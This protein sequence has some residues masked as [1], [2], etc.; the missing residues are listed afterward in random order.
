MLDFLHL[1]AGI[2]S[3]Q[4]PPHNRPSTWEGLRLTTLNLSI[5]DCKSRLDLQLKQIGFISDNEGICYQKMSKFYNL[6]RWFIF[7]I[8]KTYFRTRLS[9][10][11]KKLCSWY[12][13]LTSKS[14]RIFSASPLFL[15]S[16]KYF[17]FKFPSSPFP[18]TA[19]QFLHNTYIGI[20]FLF[21]DACCFS[22]WFL[23]FRALTIGH[24]STTHRTIS[25]EFQIVFQAFADLRIHLHLLIFLRL[26][27]LISLGTLYTCTSAAR[28]TRRFMGLNQDSRSV[29]FSL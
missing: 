7:Y 28:E 8:T 13:N 25:S 22:S 9:F 24:L 12:H 16:S 2:D 4:A 11:F 20:G 21:S 29:L 19:V 26:Y 23:F 10:W 3:R 1:T 17:P 6:W 15:I 18:F 5:S 27:L 14:C